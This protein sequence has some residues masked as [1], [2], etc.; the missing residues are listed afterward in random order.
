[1]FLV[2]SRLASFAAPCAIKHRE[3]LSRSYGRFIAEFLNA[4]FP[5]HL[6]LLDHP[7]GV[8]LR[9]GL[10]KLCERW[11]SWKQKGMNLPRLRGVIEILVQLTWGICLPRSMLYQFYVQSIYT[12][13][14]SH[15]V[16]PLLDA[17]SPFSKGYLYHSRL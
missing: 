7:T 17:I 14:S 5:V 16:T 9:Y 15:S 12:L 1:M 8:G 4:S 3:S 13:Q 10:W 2:N 11:F 6:G